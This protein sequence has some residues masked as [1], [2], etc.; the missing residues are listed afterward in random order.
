MSVVKGIPRDAT[1]GQLR[2]AKLKGMSESGIW[3]VEAVKNMAVTEPYAYL[4]KTEPGGKVMNKTEEVVNN[5][6][7]AAVAITKAGGVVRDTA[8][9]TI[10]SMTD[11]NRKLRENTNKLTDSIGVFLK[12]ANKPEYIKAINDMERLAAAL[13]KIAE[14]EKAGI[15]NKLAAVVK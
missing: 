9:A 15:L 7:E 1:A 4:S 13:E 3:S 11:S 14:L 10:D 8:N 2:E 5:L 6:T 12:T